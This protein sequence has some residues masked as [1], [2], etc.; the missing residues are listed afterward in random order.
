VDLTLSTPLDYQVL[1]R[2]SPR[3]WVPRFADELSEEEPAEAAVQVR[4]VNDARQTPWV[5]VNSVKG[6]KIIAT[7]DAPAGG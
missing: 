1:Q 3:K 6:W 2:S 4:V 7:F 5:Q